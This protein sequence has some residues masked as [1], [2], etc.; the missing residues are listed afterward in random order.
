MARVCSYPPPGSALA[1]L[2]KLNGINRLGEPVQVEHQTTEHA[3]SCIG[4]H[5]QIYVGIYIQCNIH[6]Y[7]QEDRKTADGAGY[8]CRLRRPAIRR[9]PWI[10]LGMVN[11]IN[12]KPSRSRRKT[13][14]PLLPPHP[15]VASRGL[16]RD[17]EWLSFLPIHPSLPLHDVD[18]I[19]CPYQ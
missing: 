7:I 16:P 6:T 1:G 9:P 19:R 13:P 8:M 15:S 3:A 12:K 17:N 18:W 10:A 14:P 11:H 5:I 2:W 4:R